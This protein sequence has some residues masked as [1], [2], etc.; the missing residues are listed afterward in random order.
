MEIGNIYEILGTAGSLIMCASSV[1]QIIKTY[2]QKSVNSLSGSY[3]L[4]L[5][6][7]CC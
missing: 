3:L 1:P 5:L 6:W 7:E 4:F 2:R